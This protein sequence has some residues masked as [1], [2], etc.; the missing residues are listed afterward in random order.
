MHVD[1]ELIA[2]LVEEIVGRLTNDRGTEHVLV[3]ASRNAGSS[4]VLP[5]GSGAERK[6]FFYDESYDGQR[7]DRYVLPRLEIN[8]MVDLALGKA[9]TPAAEMVRSLVLSGKTVEV[10]E[11]VY[12][13]HE[14]T[15][16]PPLYQLYSR[17]AE[18]LRAFGLTPARAVHKRVR[19]PNRVISEKELEACR[20]GGIKRIDIAPGA[21]VTSLAEDYARKYGM[22]IQRS[23]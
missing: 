3:I 17:Y 16:P 1:K 4:I 22:E 12:T 7:I 6:L 10:L 13:A 8:D 11:Y 14:S 2:R 5:Q 18:T 20:A 19:L 21:L 15:A 9:V 23:E